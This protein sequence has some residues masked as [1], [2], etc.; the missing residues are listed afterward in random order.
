MTRPTEPVPTP[1][2]VV[3]IAAGRPVTAVW[4][5]ELGGITFA[6]DGGAEYVKVAPHGFDAE[7]LRLDWAFDRL[8]VP[9]VLGTGSP[10]VCSHVL[11]EPSTRGTVR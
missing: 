10:L 8:K 6:I 5:N 4:A 3:D 7:I 9:R 11:P 2:V 1:A